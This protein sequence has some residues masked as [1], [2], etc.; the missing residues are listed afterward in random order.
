[1]CAIVQKR[2]A[3][4]CKT[5]P[6]LAGAKNWN[7]VMTDVYVYHFTRIGAV[8]EVIVSKR[9]ATLDTIG[10]L[11]DA[12]LESQLVVD[13]TEVDES[14]FLIG[15]A[16]D[17]RHPTDALWA[18]IRSLER[19]A[20]SRDEAALCLTEECDVKI[21]YVLSLESRELRKQAQ[22]LRKRRVEMM[23][24][25]LGNQLDSQDFRPFRAPGPTAS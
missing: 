24:G 11:G 16:H 23:S 19:R 20:H 6:G 21:R 15:Y 2:V 9:W 17:E 22:A 8:G 7:N 13:H 1:M 14:G 25:A 3:T 12:V 5:Y 18:Q 4:S 10:Q